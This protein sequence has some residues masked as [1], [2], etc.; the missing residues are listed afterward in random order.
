VVEVKKSLKE[1]AFALVDIFF[2]GPE[3]PEHLRQFQ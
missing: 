2:G 1:F 3:D